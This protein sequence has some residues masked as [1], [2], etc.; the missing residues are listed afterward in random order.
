MAIAS[1]SRP[2]SSA[3]LGFHGEREALHVT[4]ARDD[5]GHD[6]MLVKALEGDAHRLLLLRVRVGLG[7][8]QIVEREA[9]W[10]LGHGA[11]RPV[12]REGVAVSGIGVHVEEIEA[13]A[14]LV[15]C[16]RSGAG[17]LR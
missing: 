15:V 11:G 5:G 14:A 8:Q 12:E 10:V 3:R 6:R 13:D 16:A 7:R 1:Q 2:T 9:E 4:V 17:A